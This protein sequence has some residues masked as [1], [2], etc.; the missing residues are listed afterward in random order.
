VSQSLA[1]NP[2]KHSN[3][4]FNDPRISFVVRVHHHLPLRLIFIAIQPHLQLFTRIFCSLHH[5]ISHLHHLSHLIFI[6]FIFIF[7]IF[8]FFIFIFFI[9]IFFIFIFFIFNGVLGVSFFLLPTLFL[10]PTK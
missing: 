3:K 6:I 2:S 8:I 1:S 5:F 7:F 10:L 9:F 4:I